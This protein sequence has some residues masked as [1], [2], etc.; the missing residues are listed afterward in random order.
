MESTSFDDQIFEFTGPL[1]PLGAKVIHHH[2]HHNL[3]QSQQSGGHSIQVMLGIPGSQ[4]SQQQQH[5]QQNSPDLCTQRLPE[6]HSLLPGSPKID[7]YKNM[8]YSNGK[9][10]T[11]SYSPN[12]KMD[13]S[14]NMDYTTNGKMD[15]A[16]KMDYD[17]MNNIF[18]QPQPIDSNNMNGLNI[19]R[20]SD[21]MNVSGSSTPTTSQ[22]SGNSDASSTS[23]I[24]KNDNKKKTDPNGV[25]KK[26]TR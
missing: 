16:N 7:H 6:V 3:L 15:Y 10:D 14:K 20:K 23:N 8:D 22:C 17:H 4:Q 2:H 18:Q 12:S 25:K 19:K 5:H 11:T 21:D 9:L 26:K 24:K 1:S 13:Y